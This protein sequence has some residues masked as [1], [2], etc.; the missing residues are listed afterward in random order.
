MREQ[1]LEFVSKFLKKKKSDWVSY[2]GDNYDENEYISAIETLMDGWLVF[3]PRCREFEKKFSQQLGRRHGI[4]TN[5][6]SSANLLM[7]AA[8]KSPNGLNFPEG[9]KIITPAVCFPTTI[10]PIIQMGFEPVFV[11]V[12]LPNMNLNLDAV[13]DKLKEDDDIKGICFAHVAGNPPDMERLVKLSNK[14]NVHIFEDCCDA[15]GSSVNGKKLGSFGTMSTCSFYPAHHMSTAEGGY[16]ATDDPKL[17]RTLNSLR[18]WG[19]DCYC[20]IGKPG[21]VTDGTACGNRFQSWLKNFPEIIYDHRYVYREIGYN[22]KPIEIQGAFGLEQLKK[23]PMMEKG[24]KDNYNKLRNIFSRYKDFIIAESLEGVDTCWFCF[25]I[26]V[27]TNSKFTKQDLVQHLENDKIQTR[28]YFAGNV[29][30]HPAYEKFASKY[31]CIHTAFPISKIA[32]TNSFF[33][34]TYSGLTDDCINRIEKSLKT[35][36]EKQNVN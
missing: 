27:D 7:M 14:Y 23:L 18:D 5:S 32:T 3:G 20:N 10:N 17:F 31:D 36:M 25:L 8:A 19:R 16:V 21:C 30:Y 28:P 1:I 6:G 11:D 13:E 26:T 2:S 15:L 34:G 9:S 35:F 24:R 22:L 29:L 12:E 33:L 4:Y